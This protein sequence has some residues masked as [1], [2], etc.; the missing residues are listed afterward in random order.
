MDQLLA[1][2]TFARVVEAGS[3]TKAADS[4]QMPKATVTKLVQALEKHVGAKLLQ[5]TTRRLSVTP[6]GMAYYEKTARVVKDLADIDGEFGA[7]H[8]TPK[9]HLRIDVGG[10]LAWHVLIPALPDF[11]ARYPEI[12][13]DLGVSDRHAD[14][15]ADNVD[16]VIRGGPLG[17]SI[18]VPRK[19][20]AVPWVTC[21]TPAYLA[22]YGTPKH[23]KDLGRGHVVASY[24]S[25]RTRRAVPMSFRRGG[26][27][28]EPEM[29]CAVSVNESN[30]HVAAG[31]AGLGLIQTFVIAVRDYMDKG[32]LVPVLEDWQPPDYPFYLVYPP[33]R[34]VSSRMRVFIDWLVE[35]FDSNIDPR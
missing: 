19:L 4:N 29:R 3:F 35:S 13:V 33:N 34:H 27:K 16:C 5:R 21:A 26:A 15:V 25:T 6:E 14:L 12:Q 31:L 9:G 32:K 23:P 7:R 17:D 11:L 20:G 18:L 22:R 2:R 8:R 30:A 1:I 10:S 24:L 28:F